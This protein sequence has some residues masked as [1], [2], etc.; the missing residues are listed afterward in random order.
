MRLEWK[1]DMQLQGQAVKKD[2]QEFGC[3]YLYEKS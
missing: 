2:I 3:N 1:R